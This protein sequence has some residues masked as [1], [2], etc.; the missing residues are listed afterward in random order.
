MSEI[1]TKPYLVRAL[2][3]WC[4]DSGYTPYVAV[5]VG[6]NVVVPFEYVKDGEIVLNV[7]PLATNRLSIG[8]ELLE[9]Q[10]RFGGVAREVRVPVENIRAIYA[11]ETGQGMAFEAMAER[12]PGGEAPAADPSAAPVSAPASAPAGAARPAAGTAPTLRVLTA[13]GAEPH[14]EPP[15]EPPTEPPQGP[16]PGDRPRLTR[17]K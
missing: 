5:A 8:N 3:E 16:G 10:A 14:E 17:V 12:N 4:N 1:S 15:T 6:E 7:S 9:F 2:F 13:P 11:R